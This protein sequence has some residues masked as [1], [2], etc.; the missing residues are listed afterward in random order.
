MITE[1][2]VEPMIPEICFEPIITEISIELMMTE[3]SIEQILTEISH[4]YFQLGIEAS[5]PA[6]FLAKAK[7]IVLR[8][9]ELDMQATALQNAV[10]HLDAEQQKLVGCS[11][12]WL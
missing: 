12:G 3:I 2:S 1:I 5:T 4:G 9:K 11:A 7:E 6:E 10:A 8:H